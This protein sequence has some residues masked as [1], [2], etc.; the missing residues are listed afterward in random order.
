MRDTPTDWQDLRHFAAL[1]REGSLSAAARRLAVDHATVARRV[2]ALEAALGLK[3]VDR[4]ARSYALTAEGRRIAAIAQRME[5]AAF[6]LDRAAKGAQTGLQGSVTVSTP[7]TIAAALIAP[8]LSA[9][10]AA[11]PGISLKLIGEK[12]SASLSR[13]EADIAVRLIRPQ[14][15]SLVTRRIGRLGFA[16][17]AAPAYLDAIAPAD[18]A[19]IAY[20]DPMDQAPQQIWLRHF[21]QGRPV[22]LRASD[23]EVQ[24]E[25]AKA[26]IGIAALPRFFGESE[27]GLRRL[28]SGG[29][30]LSREV[31]LA[32]HQDLRRAPLVRATLDFLARCFDRLP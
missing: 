9:L 26:G 30:N 18:Y 14:E 13:R 20:D 15:K 10:Y 8:R 27:P 23:L 16:L 24:R 25:A 11:H 6:E 31:W 29:K 19:F 17:Y 1:A 22:V 28:E 5:A 3:L 4:R 32:V 12:R 7:P 2:A 21:A